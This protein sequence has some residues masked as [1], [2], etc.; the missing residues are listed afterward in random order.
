MDF[1]PLQQ[2]ALELNFDAHGVVATVTPPGESAIAT[3]GIWLD[4]RDEDMPVGTEYRGKE[5][6]RVMALRRDE[7]PD[8]PL[9]TIIVAPET[10]GGVARNW[11]V[12]R[13]LST[14]PNHV[15]VILIPVTGV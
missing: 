15:N 3:T 1:G 11:Q 14:K 8:A 12:D 9:K 2:L 10:S 4:A 6:R 5:P 7:V 13:T